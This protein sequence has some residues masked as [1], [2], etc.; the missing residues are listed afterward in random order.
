MNTEEKQQFIENIL[1]NKD[2]IIQEYLNCPRS[3]IPLYTFDGTSTLI[4]EWRA[5]TLWW[6]QKPLR[7]FQKHMPLTTELLQ[8]GPEHNG[9][10]WLILNPHAETPVHNHI[11]WGK[12]IIMHFPTVIPEGDVGF[13]VEGKIHRWKVGELFAFDATTNHYGFNHT[14]EMRSILSMDF[15]YDEW[16]ETLKPYMTLE[17]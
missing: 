8:H 2:K 17:D 13:W 4:K 1:H 9:T 14:D 3:S 5:I 12:N 16:Y 7:F 15:K 6:D 11:P 10:G